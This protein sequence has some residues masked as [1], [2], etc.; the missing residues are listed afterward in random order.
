MGW[1]ILREKVIL[2]PEVV[3]KFRVLEFHRNWEIR[4]LF[5]LLSVNFERYLFPAASHI[6]AE[7]HLRFQVL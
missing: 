2:E 7:V 6:L 4:W 5:L 1:Y 3:S